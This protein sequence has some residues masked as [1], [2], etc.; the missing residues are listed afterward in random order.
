MSKPIGRPALGRRLHTPAFDAF[1]AVKGT[2]CAAL[3][4]DHL[5]S[6]GHLADLRSGR[7]LVSPLTAITLAEA[8]GLSSPDAIL[9]P[10]MQPV[11]A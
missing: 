4:K 7:R 5:M 8:L 11:A 3:A 9:W 6:E 10:A 2:N 1:C